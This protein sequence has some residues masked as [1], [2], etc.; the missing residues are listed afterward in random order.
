MSGR[1]R[2]GGGLCSA[3]S[4]LRTWP[5]TNSWYL[6][7]S[8]CLTCPLT[9]ALLG[10]AR[11]S[12]VR[13][14]KAAS[15]QTAAES[16]PVKCGGC[17]V[18]GGSCSCSCSSTNTHQGSFKCFRC[19]WN[20]QFLFVCLSLFHRHSRANGHASKLQ[21]VLLWTG[22]RSYRFPRCLSC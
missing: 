14:V 10:S 8:L 11:P 22:P 15:V 5:E 6:P 19:W 20:N 9:F 2:W 21:R 4:R 3:V 1:Q 16:F 17:S 12:A 18:P 7:G 13:S